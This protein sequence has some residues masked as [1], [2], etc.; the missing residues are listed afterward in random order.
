MAA[1]SV[2]KS[3]SL[4][5]SCHMSER[6]RR[7]AVAAFLL[8]A[9]ISATGLTALAAN[10]AGAGGPFVAANPAVSGS[11]APTYV[12]VP[13]DASGAAADPPRRQQV[14]ER[15]TV[16]GGGGEMSAVSYVGSAPVCVRLCDGAFFPLAAASGDPAAQA[17][18]C[19]SQC[20]D[21][22]TEVFY[23][24]GSDGI[25]DAISASGQRYTALPAALRFQKSSDATCACH[26][27]IVAYAPMS[28]PTLRPGDA[29]MTSAGIL[30]FRGVEGGPHLP[31]DFT[32]LSDGN[33]PPS[34]RVDLQAMERVS[35]A[36]NGPT[37]RE[38]LASQDPPALAQRRIQRVATRAA[39]D[40]DKICLL[41]WRG[42]AED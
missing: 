24:D 15:I 14:R 33:L 36:K 8:G 12:V 10:R 37:T 27:H 42:G 5:A 1:R 29:I 18:A 34:R 9:A 40:G 30:V 28:D 32:A 38:W 4:A 20:P 41:V 35:V 6:R 13:I 22:P 31:G 23:R 11:F 2:F 17:A 3:P 21:A 39:D 26:R 25:E 19:D 16:I 7:L